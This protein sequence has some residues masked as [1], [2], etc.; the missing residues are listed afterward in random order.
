MVVLVGE[1]DGDHHPGGAQHLREHV[2]RGGA[3]HGGEHDGLGAEGGAQR[4]LHHWDVLV[5]QRCLARGQAGVELHLDVAEA[6]ASKVLPQQLGHIL[7]ELAGDDAHVD[8]ALGLVHR[9]VLAAVE[10]PGVQAADVAGGLEH[11]IIVIVVR[12]APLQEVAGAPVGELRRSVEG[13]QGVDRGELLPGGHHGLVIKSVD[14][15][16][17]FGLLYGG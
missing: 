11:V 4:V 7:R 16:G 9:D 17:A 6:A 1:G 15:H 2:E 10:I 12:L 5:V 3:A 14:E 8:E 13:G